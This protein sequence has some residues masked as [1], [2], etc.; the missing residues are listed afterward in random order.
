LDKPPPNE[1]FFV[2]DINLLTTTVRYAKTNEVSTINNFSISK[3]RII[4]LQRSQN[5]ILDFEYK[6]KDSV[7]QTGAHIKFREQVEQ[8]IANHPRIW[9]RLLFMRHDEI[10]NDWG[11]VTF[12][13]AIRHCSSWQ[14]AGRIMLHRADILRFF[15]DI[16]MEANILWE[17]PI[18][19]RQILD[20]GT[21]TND[22]ITP[23]KP[24][25]LPLFTNLLMPTK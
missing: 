24:T 16:G 20:G 25:D 18:Q 13:I 19:R 5:A 12:H 17:T 7:L 14:N 6:F 9:D 1:S 2:E 22:I 11:N 15:Y 8:Y 3:S 21:I 4:N 10:D 23:R